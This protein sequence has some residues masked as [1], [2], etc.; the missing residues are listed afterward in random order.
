MATPYKPPAPAHPSKP[1]ADS[2]GRRDVSAQIKEEWGKKSREEKAAHKAREDDKAIL[3][4]NDAKKA[5]GKIENEF[6]K[7]TNDSLSKIGSSIASSPPPPPA[8]SSTVTKSDPIAAPTSNPQGEPSSPFI[9]TVIPG[10]PDTYGCILVIDDPS[11][12]SEPPIRWLEAPDATN[13]YIPVLEAGIWMM[14]KVEP[15]Y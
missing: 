4:A 14:V 7:F 6:V 9:G 13:S 2:S 3:Q 12:V 5:H 15:C 11:V 8:I 1:L 10:P